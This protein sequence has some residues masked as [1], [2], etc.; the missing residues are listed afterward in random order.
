MNKI[1]CDHFINF[2]PLKLLIGDYSNAVIVL[3]STELTRFESGVFQ[4][5][6]EDMARFD[7]SYINLQSSILIC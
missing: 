2:K 7:T 1:C 6:L 4:S 3:E 5:V